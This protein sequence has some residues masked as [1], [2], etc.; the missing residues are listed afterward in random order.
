MLDIH[1]YERRWWPP[2][3]LSLRVM[4]HRDGQRCEILHPPLHWDHTVRDLVLWIATALDIAPEK[5]KL[6]AANIYLTD[7]VEKTLKESNLTP[8]QGVHCIIAD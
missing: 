6:M 7:T 4:P 8:E 2:N 5:I 3:S 1:N